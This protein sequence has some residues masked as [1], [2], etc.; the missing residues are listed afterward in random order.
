[1]Q[2]DV[3]A[4]YTVKRRGKAKF[5]VGGVVIVA[6]MAY[7][8][9][10]SVISTASYF[11]TVDELYDKGEEIH[12][13]NVRVSG[14]VAGESIDFDAKNL[15]LRFE[16]AGEDGRQLPVVFHGPQPDQ[17]YSGETEAVVEGSF[18]GETFT[19]DT[20]ML[21]CPSKYEEGVVDKIQ[22]EAVK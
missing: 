13:R 9:Y 14:M 3:S 4:T 22:V 21:K 2:A 15:V 12:G 5:V 19:A 11:L 10:S 7:L 17:I 6:A 8:I 18:D 1:M 20:L 16:M